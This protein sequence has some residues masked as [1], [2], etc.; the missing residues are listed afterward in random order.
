M[1]YT[2]V[3]SINSFL[4]E[5]LSNYNRIVDV[6]VMKIDEDILLMNVGARGF[7]LDSRLKTKNYKNIK[8]KTISNMCY[9]L[10]TENISREEVIKNIETIIRDLE[11]EVN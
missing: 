9:K 6:V 10:K 1:L 7:K 5:M 11:G 2:D 8:R 3:Q 4:D